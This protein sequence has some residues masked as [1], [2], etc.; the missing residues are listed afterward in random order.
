MQDKVRDLRSALKRLKQ[1]E[2]QY[3]ETDVE[4]DPMAELAGVYRYVG[5][6]GT[7]SARQK[8]VQRWYLIM[9]KDIKMPE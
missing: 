1:M 2:G 3:I 5:A 9:S 4:V 8:K 7:V 6:G